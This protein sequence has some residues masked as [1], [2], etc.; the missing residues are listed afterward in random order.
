MRPTFPLLIDE[1][2]GAVFSRACNRFGSGTRSRRSG[3]LP[4]ATR[5]VMSMIRKLFSALEL[6]PAP[7]TNTEADR[8]RLARGVV[9]E[10]SHG[11]VLLQRGQYYTKEDI[12]AE[13]ESVRR[14]DLK[15]TAKDQR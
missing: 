13:Y 1:G 9:A 6:P 10:R 11:N 2:D 15:P 5:R 12:D 7:P 14:Y 4:N 3:E 8:E